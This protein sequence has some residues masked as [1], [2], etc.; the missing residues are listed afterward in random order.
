[1]IDDA[2]AIAQLTGDELIVRTG[3]GTL[4]LLSGKDKTVKVFGVNG[5][6]MSNLEL[7]SGV[8][9]T[10]KLPAGIYVVENKKVT[11]R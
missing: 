1:M 11:V 7:V 4:S 9:T 10:I 6:L 2:T 3:T 5:V 8:S